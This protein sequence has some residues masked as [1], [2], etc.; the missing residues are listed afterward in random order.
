[1]SKD[2]YCLHCLFSLST[3]VFRCKNLSESLQDIT[4]LS[5]RYA[6]PRMH[7]FLKEGDEEFRLG[8]H[9]D[10]IAFELTSKTPISFFGGLS[11]F[12]DFQD[13]KS[14]HEL[15]SSCFI[16]SF[17]PQSE[18]LRA[19]SARQVYPG[20]SSLDSSSFGAIWL[21]LQEGV[22]GVHSV[23]GWLNAETF[24]C[25]DPHSHSVF[26]FSFSY[27][28]GPSGDFFSFSA[29]LREDSKLLSVTSL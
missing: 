1:M 17:E 5:S 13:D 9:E 11:L 8:W 14:T 10:G 28:W 23:R 22:N 15:S 27:S 24:H 6:L 12:F 21:P 2:Q 7:F 26:G 3:K 19:L 16:F 29:F 20:E 25:Y 18:K 4:F